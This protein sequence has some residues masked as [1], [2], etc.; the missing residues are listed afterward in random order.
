M[1]SCQDFST[2]G[3]LLNG[4]KF[5]KTSVLVMNGDTI[6]IPSSKSFQCLLKWKEIHE[7]RTPHPTLTPSVDR[8]DKDVGGYLITTHCL[9]SGSYAS[10]YL[11]LNTSA[12]RQVACKVI[13]RKEGS[14]LKK[15]MKEATLLMKFRHPNIN[16]VY[17]VDSDPDFLY[18]MLQLSTGGDLFTYITTSPR[19]RLGEGEAKWIM[20]QMLN[21]IKYLH[22]RQIS[23]RDL[24]VDILTRCE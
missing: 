11:A 19:K 14:D 8:V 20:Y 22:D 17:A 16:K 5:R 10:V 15:E 1:I 3:L 6:K 18:I 23:H 4:H 21:A 2:N 7:R 24:K 9:G 12:Q 13:K